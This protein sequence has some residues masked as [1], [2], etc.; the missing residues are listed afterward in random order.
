MEPCGQIETIATLK[1]N[2]KQM[3]ND[4]QEMKGDLK[5]TNRNVKLFLDTAN[6]LFATKQEN[7]DLQKLLEEKHQLNAKR[8]DGI[9]R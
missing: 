4:I 1:A 8:I 7:K 2:Y 5:E 9:Y 6:K 3:A